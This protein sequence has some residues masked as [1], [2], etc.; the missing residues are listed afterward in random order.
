MFDGLRAGGR[1][2]VEVA[3]HHVELAG[4]RLLSVDGGPAPFTPKGG[5]RPSAG[6]SGL[7][8]REEADEL[9]AVG[10]WLRREARAGQVRVVGPIA[11][12][13]AAALARVLEGVESAAG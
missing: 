11:P 1:I 10:R 13:S 6:G 8:G 4:G 12:E 2:T 3:G 5:V 9:L 7:P